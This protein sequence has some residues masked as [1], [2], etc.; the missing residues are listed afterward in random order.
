MWLDSQVKDIIN[1]KNF[2]N[3]TDITS[4]PDEGY[5]RTFN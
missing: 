5:C 4:F 3:H 2:I 1:I